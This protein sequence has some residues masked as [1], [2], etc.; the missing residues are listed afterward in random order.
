MND[1]KCNENYQYNEHIPHETH[2][3]KGIHPIVLTEILNMDSLYP[4]ELKS[5]WEHTLVSFLILYIITMYMRAV[6]FALMHA[7]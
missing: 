3:C 7:F 2:M 6:H 1:L 4:A 5:C